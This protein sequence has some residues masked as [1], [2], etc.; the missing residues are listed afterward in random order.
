MY[1][2]RSIAASSMAASPITAPNTTCLLHRPPKHAPRREG[3]VILVAHA[4]RIAHRHAHKPCQAIPNS[5]KA[6][7]YTSPKDP[8]YLLTA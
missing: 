6:L 5:A 2:S 8:T 3:I 1:T 4:R 7:H